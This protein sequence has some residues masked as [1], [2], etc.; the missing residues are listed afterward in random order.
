VRFR[1]AVDGD[2]HEV[3]VTRGRR[4]LAVT[5]D[6]VPYAASVRTRDAVFSVTIGARRHRVEI[7][8]PRV[9]VD[10]EPVDVLVRDLVDDRDER[11]ARGA[12][13]TGILEIRPP[14]PG[15]VVRVT[16]SPGTRVRRGDP[17]AVLEAMK[18]QNEIVSPADGRV[19]EVFVQVGETIAADRVIASLEAW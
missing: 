15:R 3:V 4:G 13:P 12:G 2:V 18:M 6:G 16:V 10:G 14:M 19:R 1:L 11:R 7:R 5:V 9:V 17:I 8:G